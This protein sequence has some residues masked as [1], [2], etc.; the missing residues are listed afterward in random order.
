MAN[1]ITGKVISGLVQAL[2]RRDRPP[3]WGGS[4]RRWTWWLQGRSA[5]SGEFICQAG[6]RQ[7]HLLELPGSD[8]DTGEQHT[9]QDD[10]AGRAADINGWAGLR[11]G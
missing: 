6:S 2:L 9:G 5:L 1:H 4:P 10:Q 11:A 3:A 7:F 8:Q